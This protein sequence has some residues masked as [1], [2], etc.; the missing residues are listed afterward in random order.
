VSSAPAELEQALVETT[1]ELVRIPSVTGDER[2]ICDA[3]EAR[4]RRALP[5]GRVLRFRDTLVAWPWPRRLGGR[6]WG[7]SATWTRS[8]TTTTAWRASRT[9]ASSAAASAT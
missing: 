2:A 4:L 1:L 8:P 9:G 6:W 3:V 5:A 7:S